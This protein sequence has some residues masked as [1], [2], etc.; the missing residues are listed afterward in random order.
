MIE[1]HPQKVQELMALLADHI[2]RGRST[3]GPDRSNAP[4]RPTGTWPQVS[5]MGE[6]EA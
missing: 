2:R 4:N 3:P 6:E 1:Q 5:W